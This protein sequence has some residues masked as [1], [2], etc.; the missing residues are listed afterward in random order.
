MII[1]VFL[2]FSKSSDTVARSV[3]LWGEWVHG[4]LG[5]VLAEVEV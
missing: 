1:P 3:L 2:E 5:E 4:A